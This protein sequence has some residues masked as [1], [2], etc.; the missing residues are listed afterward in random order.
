[1]V[2]AP[3]FIETL[4]C[5]EVKNRVSLTLLNM[6]IAPHFIETLICMELKDRVSVSVVALPKNCSNGGKM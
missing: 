6:V 1:M 4:I 5:M 3:H 2:M